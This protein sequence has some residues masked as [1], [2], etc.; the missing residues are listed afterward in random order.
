[1]YGFAYLFY[2]HLLDHYASLSSLGVSKIRL[3][4]ALI[5]SPGGILSILKPGDIFR[6]Y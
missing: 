3:A 4:K 5:V 1:M 6:L 2:D